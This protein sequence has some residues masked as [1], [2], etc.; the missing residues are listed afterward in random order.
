M[1]LSQEYAQV[2][3]VQANEQIVGLVDGENSLD[4]VETIEKV[5]QTAAAQY[6]GQ[7]YFYAL[8]GGSPAQSL[9]TIVRPKDFHPVSNRKYWAL[10]GQTGG[11]GG[12][13]G[14]VY[15][16]EGHPEGVQTCISGACIYVQLD[17]DPPGSI[18]SYAGVPG[19]NIGW[20]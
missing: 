19:G 13:Q 14:E 20:S 11:G 15:A 1:N 2:L 10:I 4:A 17:S 7:V 3:F 18:I 9:P 6:S 16:G 8:R 12:G 5:L